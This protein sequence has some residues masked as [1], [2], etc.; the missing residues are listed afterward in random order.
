MSS[1]SM[2]QQLENY[3]D[4]FQKHRKK[5][6]QEESL[7]GKNY[8]GSTYTA[9]DLLFKLLPRKAQ[10]LMKICAFL[11]HSSI[12]QALSKDLCHLAFMPTPSSVPH[13]GFGKF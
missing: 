3:L 12:P 7:K 9:S 5:L 10:E 1:T 2:T 4:I 6:M 8:K 13:Q 11:H